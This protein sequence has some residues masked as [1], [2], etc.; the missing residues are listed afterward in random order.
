MVCTLNIV[1]I[2]YGLCLEFLY[3]FKRNEE[4]F[5]LLLLLCDMVFNSVVRVVIF[6]CFKEMYMIVVWM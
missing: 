2:N 6:W 4:G 1:C 5:W 3:I